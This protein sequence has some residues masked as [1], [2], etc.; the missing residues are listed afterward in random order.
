MSRLFYQPGS[1][2]PQSGGP[3]HASTGSTC[4]SGQGNGDLV[5]KV[6]LQNGGVATFTFSALLDPAYVGTVSTVARAAVPAGGFDGDALNNESRDEDQATPWADLELSMRSV[7]ALSTS[8]G[9]SSQANSEFVPGTNVTFLIEVTNQGPSVAN[10]FGISNQLPGNIS[11]VSV[12]CTGVDASCGLN[13][14][15]GNLVQFTGMS[16]GASSGNLI[17][18]IVVGFINPAAVGALSTTASLVIPPLPP[19]SVWFK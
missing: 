14:S 13:S 19:A 8:G 7:T 15:V 17:R 11:L 4:T 18:L 6:N 9:F 10:G 12:G 3:A 1:F 16:L 5:T 2:Q